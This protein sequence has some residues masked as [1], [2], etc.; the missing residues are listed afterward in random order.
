MIKCSQL[1]FAGETCL[2]KNFLKTMELFILIIKSDVYNIN[3]YILYKNAYFK[4]KNK[5]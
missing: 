5:H 4:W 1:I 3:F 2:T